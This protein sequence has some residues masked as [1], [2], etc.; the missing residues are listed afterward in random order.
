MCHHMVAF[1]NEH[2]FIQ[3]KCQS[4]LC[5]SLHTYAVSCKCFQTKHIKQYMPR[6]YHNT[7]QV[8]DHPQI[9]ILSA[10]LFSFPMDGNNDD[11]YDFLL[12]LLTYDCPI[13]GQQRTAGAA[14]DEPQQ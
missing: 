3:G 10:L 5:I 1:P 12:D 7:S 8:R 11:G 14:S 6:K 13:T 9:A 4:M 2:K